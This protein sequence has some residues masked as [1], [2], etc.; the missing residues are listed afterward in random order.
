MFGRMGA[1]TLPSSCLFVSALST[2]D[3][4]ESAV[5]VVGAVLHAQLIERTVADH[6]G[7]LT[8]DRNGLL[9]LIAEKGHP[10]SAIDIAE[11]GTVCEKLGIAYNGMGVESVED[12]LATVE[13]NEDTVDVFILGPQSIGIDNAGKIVPATPEKPLVSCSARPVQ[14]GAPG[15]F[16][17]DQKL[18][19]M[20]ADSMKEVL[21]DSKTAGDIPFKVDQKPQFVVNAA[22]AE[23]LGLEM[24]FDI[25][26]ARV[27]QTSH[28]LT[29]GL[30]IFPQ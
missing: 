6:R 9:F 23:K 22:A 13:A 25:L 5:E 10:S 20:I 7:E 11:T 14:D 8:D 21:V 4:I 19:A 29:V 28:S 12:A 1:S 27:H 17:N 3:A 18:G 16:D 30:R 26:Q 15:G 24:S 2:A